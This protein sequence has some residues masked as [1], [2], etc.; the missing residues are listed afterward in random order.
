MIPSSVASFNAA[1]SQLNPRALPFDVER[2]TARLTEAM[3][4][5]ELVDRETDLPDPNAVETLLKELLPFG[6][7]RW[8]AGSYR[9]AFEHKNGSVVK[10][11]V[12]PLCEWMIHKEPDLLKRVSAEDRQYFPD[13]VLLGE[14]VVLQ[15]LWIPD[16]R[17]FFQECDKIECV[18][19]RLETDDVMPDNVGWKESRFVFLDWAGEKH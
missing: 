2:V 4:S 8:G 16:F 19:R 14:A 5:E 9:A 7:L 3:L 6:F 18:A 13:T 17:R 11:P 1:D 12:S 10:V 15:S